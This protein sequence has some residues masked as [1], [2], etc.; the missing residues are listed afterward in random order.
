MGEEDLQKKEVKEQLEKER[1][2]LLGRLQDSLELPMVVLGFVWLVLL[3]VELL[4]G[5]GSVLQLI[6]NIIWVLF[7]LDFI[8]KF[9]LAP[10][11]LLFLRHNILTTISLAVPALRLFRITRA[12]RLISTV[13]ATRGLRLVKVVGSINRGM[14]SLGKAMKR[15]AFGYVLALTLVV[16]VAGAAGMYTLEQE[17]GLKTYGEA[18]WWTVMLLTSIG[19]DYFPVTPEGR[20]LCLLLA[21]YGFAVF[22]Y[23]TATIATFFIDS[24]AGSEES[25]VVGATQVKALQQEVLLLRQ[26][27][28]AFLQQ[29]QNAAPPAP[30]TKPPEV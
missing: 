1:Y 17:H 7:I 22:G 18:L 14:R 6:S 11:K 21:I 24:D 23:F 29:Q 10:Q 4:W 2:E 25:E 27:L 30:P 5:L 12:F 28:Q 8:V 20:V 13:R 3:V 26:E 16:I 19:S 9:I 15:R